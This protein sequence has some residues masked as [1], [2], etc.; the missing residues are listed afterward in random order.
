MYTCYLGLGSNLGNRG[1][2]LRRALR[3][4]FM[5]P[6]TTLHEVSPFYETEPWGNLDQGP[7][8]NGVACITTELSPET[9]LTKCQE[10]E[11]ELGRNRTQEEHWGPRSI[12][13]DL[14]LIKGIRRT[15]D[16][17]LPHPYIKE[18]A[19]V[20]RPLFDIAPHIVIDG[21]PIERILERI[22]VDGVHLAAEINDPFPLSMI[23]SVDADGGIGYQGELLEHSREDMDYFRRMTMGGAV[24]MGRATM[25]SLP[26]STPLVG[27]TN[28]VLSTTL[29]ER[30]GFTVVKDMEELWRVLG[31]FQ[32]AHET[33]RLW[34]IGGA[35]TYE[36]L[37]PYTGEVFLTEFPDHHKADVFFPPLSGFTQVSSRRGKDCIYQYFAREKA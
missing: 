24:I 17:I 32:S 27:R 30:Q 6:K 19:F 36:S 7:F 25:E 4:V 29:K 34:C 15:T 20:L 22:S 5:L 9:L 21:D 16:P 31:A 35:K 1:E 8:L 3:R 23:V 28:I 18:R 37:L 33:A 2:Q 10:I 12:D 14:L 11:T 13:I 26:G